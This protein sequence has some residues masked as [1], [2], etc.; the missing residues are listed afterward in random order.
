MRL[1]R[2]LYPD[3]AVVAEPHRERVRHR[4]LDR[5]EVLLLMPRPRSLIPVCRAR[6]RIRPLPQLAEPPALVAQPRV[7]VAHS[8]SIPS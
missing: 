8:G 7:Q 5:A 6:S 1:L 2:R 3:P 4:S